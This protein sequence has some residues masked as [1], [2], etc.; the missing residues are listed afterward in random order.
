MLIRRLLLAFAQKFGILLRDQ[1]TGKVLGRVLII[2]FK[3][4]L[5]VIGLTAAV[6]PEFLTQT[7]VTYWRQELGFSTL[8]EP[9][10]PSEWQEGRTPPQQGNR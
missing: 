1:R 8:P 4:K 10:F 2:P 3:G 6:R 5:W 7:R 9:D